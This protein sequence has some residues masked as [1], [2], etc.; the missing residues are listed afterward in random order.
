MKMEAYCDR[1]APRD[2]F[3]LTGLARIGALDAEAGAHPRA[4][5]ATALVAEGAGTAGSHS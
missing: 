5:L 4:A 2:L 3:D 1:H